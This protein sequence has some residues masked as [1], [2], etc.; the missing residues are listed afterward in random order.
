MCKHGREERGR[1]P[2]IT[3]VSGLQNRRRAGSEG[4][5]GAGACS[6][7]MSGGNSF[8]ILTQPCEVKDVPIVQT[9]KLKLRKNHQFAQ[10]WQSPSANLDPRTLLLCTVSYC[11][12]EERPKITSEKWH[13]VPKASE[14][15]RGVIVPSSPSSSHRDLSLIKEQLDMSNID[16]VARHLR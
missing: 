1:G 11:S 9:R 5:K 7:K 16:Q 4:D 10:G 12:Y 6:S 14:R 3:C 8:L 15:Q 2:G 13:C